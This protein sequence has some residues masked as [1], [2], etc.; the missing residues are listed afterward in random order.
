MRT[1]REP[2]LLAA[3]SAV[4]LPI[5]DRDLLPQQSLELGVQ[6]GLI[7]LDDQQVVGVLLGHQEGGVIALGVQGVGGD[8]ASIQVKVFQQGPE[9]GD[10]VG[11]AVN[12]GLGQD[13]ARVVIQRRQQVHG[14]V[15]AAASAAQ[16]LAVHGDRSTSPLVMARWRHDAV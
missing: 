16:C 12:V 11:L 6:G 3:V 1:F 7:L 10:L 9:P 13:Q 15:L 8:D 4:A 14:A 5:T 2:A